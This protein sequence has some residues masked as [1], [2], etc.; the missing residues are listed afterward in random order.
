MRDI[1]LTSRDLFGRV[2]F[3]VKNSTVTGL[4]LLIQKVTMM[5]LSDSKTTFFNKVVGGSLNAAGKFN[6]DTSN[7]D[8]KIFILDGIGSI[9][10]KIAVDES[11]MNVPFLDRLQSIE[12]KDV[13]FDKET[14]QVSLSLLIASNSTSRTIILPVK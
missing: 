12:I 5:L 6:Y 14:L 9:K 2:T 1:D 7:K 13:L 8:F 4:E 3:G 11:L 10:N